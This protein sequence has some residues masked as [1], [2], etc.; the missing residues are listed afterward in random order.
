MI[1][2][3]KQWLQ[4]SIKMCQKHKKKATRNGNSEQLTKDNDTLR[5]DV[6]EITIH[7]LYGHI[8]GTRR[9]E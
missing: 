7:C 5:N 2:M 4:K 9:N 6:S 8:V 3:G 1:N